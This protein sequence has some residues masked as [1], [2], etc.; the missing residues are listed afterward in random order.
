[1]RSGD[2]REVYGQEF[3]YLE[4]GNCKRLVRG[5]CIRWGED[6]LDCPADNAALVRFVQPNRP[7]DVVALVRFVQSN[8]PRTTQRSSA[9]SS[10]IALRTSLRLSALFD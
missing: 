7:A 6:A 8:H 2:R 9:S 5:K 1:M 3:K 10:R 4:C